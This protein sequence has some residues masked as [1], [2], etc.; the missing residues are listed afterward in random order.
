[1]DEKRLHALVKALFIH[2]IGHFPWFI[3]SVGTA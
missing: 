2:I 1:M 3:S